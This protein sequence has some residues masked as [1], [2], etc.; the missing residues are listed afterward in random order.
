MKKIII[1]I[2]VLLSFSAFSAALKINLKPVGWDYQYYDS[3]VR[4]MHVIYNKKD[5]KSK[6]MI[7]RRLTV[8]RPGEKLGTK[9]FLNRKC[10]KL[11][12]DQNVELDIEDNLCI[13]EMTING[14][15]NTTYFLVTKRK[16]K[17]KKRI[18][19]NSV[20]FLNTKKEDINQKLIKKI[21]EELENNNI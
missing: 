17:L 19:W 20:S 7:A 10:P 5:T 18:N 12:K 9:K 15:K 1:T 6:A 4:N 3:K 16:T 11:S 14:K 21:R 2:L 13:Q 8:L